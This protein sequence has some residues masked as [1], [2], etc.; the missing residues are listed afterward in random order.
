M[1]ELKC[2]QCGRVFNS[3]T[4]ANSFLEVFLY[5]K[6]SLESASK[7]T[8]PYCGFSETIPDRKFFGVFNY[9]ALRWII[10]LIIFIIIAAV[11]Y[12]LFFIDLNLFGP[13]IGV[14]S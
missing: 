13:G 3:P 2:K 14:R 10:L 11:F 5:K 12:Q 4:L 8:C 6:D 7:A 1:T 9:R